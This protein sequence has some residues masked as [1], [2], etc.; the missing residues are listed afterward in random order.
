[1]G[2][3]RE[4]EIDKAIETA[5]DLFWRNGYE[6]TSLSDLT[7]QMK[8][9]P[10]SFYFAFGSK[11]G[12]FKR[13][14]ERYYAEQGKTLEAACAEPTAHAVAEHLLYGYADVLTDPGHAPGCLAMNSALPCAESDSL[15]TWL[16]ELRERMRTRL[17]DRFAYAKGARDLPA[18]ADPDALARLVTVIAWGMAVEAQSGAG[19]EDLHKTVALA[20][21]RWPHAM[22]TD[23]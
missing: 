21:A 19:R 12:L 1:M 9:T 15:R 10:P 17:R 6:G 13:V 5:T 2:R 16:A 14:I 22:S 4:F 11:E 8:I 3:P 7:K 20:L 18:D 23:R